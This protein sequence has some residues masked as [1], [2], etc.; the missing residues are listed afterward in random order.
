MLLE[1][2]AEGMS[3]GNDNGSQ[4]IAQIV[5]AFL[6]EKGVYHAQLVLDR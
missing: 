4:F 5:R 1:Y 6:K 3:I 2:K